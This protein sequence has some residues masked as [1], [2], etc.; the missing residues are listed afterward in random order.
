MVSASGANAYDWESSASLGSRFDRSLNT[1]RQ[2]SAGPVDGAAALIAD[3]HMG[4][5]LTA[6]SS[7]AS[8]DSLSP[9]SPTPAPD[10]PLVTW[11]GLDS[12]FFPI[13]IATNLGSLNGTTIVSDAIGVSN[14]SDTYRF[15]VTTSSTVNFT[16]SGLSNN[17]DFR[18]IWDGNSNGLIDLTEVLA[19]ATQSSTN[20][21]QMNQSLAAGTYFVQVWGGS[22]ETAYNLT[23]STGDWYS[24]NLTDAGV[25]GQAR[26]LGQDGQFSRTDMMAILREVQDSQV[27]DA[28]ELA[29][30][31]R[32]VRDRDFM[33]SDAV[34]VL[35]NKVVN[36]EIA[37]RR[38]GIG[39][40]TAG[41]SA[42][43]M[44]RLISKWF[45]GS[46]RPLANGTYRYVNG[47]LFQD[48][49][50][51][52]DVAQ[53]NVGD[54]YF[55][56]SL[57]AMAN[58]RPGWFSNDLTS[59]N[60][61]LTDNGDGTFTVGLFRADGSR[62][63]VTVDRY[64]P[65]TSTG[66]SIYASWGGNTADSSTN[67]LWVAL[68]EKAYAQF[69]ESGWIGQENTNSYAGISGGWMDRVMEQMTGWSTT[70]RSATWMSEAQLISLVNSQE[71]LTVGFIYETIPGVESGHAYTI[72]SYDA[73]SGRFHLNNPWGYSHA[74]VSM[75][76][77]QWMWAAVQWTNS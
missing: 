48:G 43:Q 29:D 22:G 47:A 63:Y 70:S 7:G 20:A 72:T 27:I 34:H 64:L 58:E 73:A 77:L 46:D 31:R 35:S 4:L 37:N 75:A 2:Q 50:S 52:A 13:E 45:V 17:A 36:A 66:R 33:M 30:V 59:G 42:N 41:S 53:G 6:S 16:L 51:V 28:G 69:N 55:L 3:G 21:E 9:L 44:E 62:D 71:L 26:T 57:A 11:S 54:C 24:A 61:I 49:A 1:L 8:N 18:L 5:S 40:L 60:G 12:R 19:S 15:N 39:D 10:Q 65:T 67:E 68:L 56:A 76:D 25:I 23:L 14:A 74:D 32:V 38:S